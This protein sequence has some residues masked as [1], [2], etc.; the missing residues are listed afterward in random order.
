MNKYDFRKAVAYE[1]IDPGILLIAGCLNALASGVAAALWLFGIDT[2]ISDHAE[3]AITVLLASVSWL[4]FEY[5]RLWISRRALHA[6]LSV[7]ADVGGLRHVINEE[8][9]DFHRQVLWSEFGVQVKG[10]PKN[11]AGTAGSARLHP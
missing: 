6:F 7:C 5:R 9:A 4:C 2:A 8:V 10:D 1:A 3:G 11:K